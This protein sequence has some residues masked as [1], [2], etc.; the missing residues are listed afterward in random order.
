VIS[1]SLDPSG[2]HRATQ[3]LADRLDGYVREGFEA[4][5]ES[6]ASRAKTTTSFVD[7]TGALR[8]SMQSEGV[9]G[10]LADPNGMVGI[11]SFAAVSERK[12]GLKRGNK[13]RSMRG[14][15]PYGIA[16]ELGTRRI[17]ARLFMTQAL[18]AEDSSLIEGAVRA[19]FRAQGF[20]VV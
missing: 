8:N 16:L 13:R 17:K 3:E 9:T 10:R 6:I 18:N 14:G 20:E 7:R 11:V 2:L 1:I 12:I 5:L 4:T 19:G 15:Y